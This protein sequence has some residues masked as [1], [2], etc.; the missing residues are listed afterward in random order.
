M[1]GGTR[2]AGIDWAT[3]AHAVCVL[4][5]E[6]GIRAR[7]DVPNIGRSFDGLVRR[8]VKLR[9]TDVAIERPDGPLVE[10]MLDAGIRVFVIAPR[11]LKGLRTRYAQ[12][13]AKSDPGDAYVLAD[14]LRT[15]GHRLSPMAPDS[16][17]TK[18][19]RALT[20]T[21]K[22]LVEARVALEN[23]LRAQ[24]EVC[25]PGAIGLFS[26]LSSAVSIAFLRRY[27]TTRSAVRLTEA[28]LGA[29]LRRISYCGR[30][31]VTEL[32][33]K[34]KQAPE[35]G[36][37]EA[38]AGGRAVCVLALV[39]VIEVAVTKSKELEAEVVERLEFH[40]DAEVFTS[41]SAGRSHPGCLSP[42][43]DR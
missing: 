18:V 34:V 30:K 43:R 36:I 26:E 19:L 17:E 11:M 15:D 37:S 8:L 42:R 6:G 38:E 22:D 16:P 20:R 5:P 24:L 41:L 9:A 23:Q 2:F 31:P 7:F 10:A 29:F 39:D 14:V 21:R 32:L 4:E 3:N 35:A 28:R 25:F 1:K 33:A 13:G 27:P 12:A 40:R